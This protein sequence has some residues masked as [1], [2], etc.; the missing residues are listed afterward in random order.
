MTS[1]VLGLVLMLGITGQERS[2][3]AEIEALDQ[4]L[5]RAEA[6]VSQDKTRRDAANLQL[7]QIE[8]AAVRS[9]QLQSSAWTQLQRRV[10]ALARLPATT[11][12]AL[13]QSDTTFDE[14]LAD[15]RLLGHIA[16]HDRVLHDSLV[17]KGD[18][19]QAL[20]IERQNQQARFDAQAQ[21]SQARRDALVAQRQ[22]RRTLLARIRS[23]AQATHAL[24]SETT[25][26]RLALGALAQ[27]RPAEAHLARVPSGAV[28]QHVVPYAPVQ[29]P[30]S[31]ARLDTSTTPKKL[32]SHRGQLAWPATGPVRVAFGERI[33]L[34][35][36]TI[37][38]H[39]G[40]DIGA[41][42]GSRVQAIGPGRIVYAD[43]LRG[44][45]QVVIIDHQDALHAV[46]AHLASIDVN[47]GDA[48]VAGQTLG[49]VGDTGS[50][51]G[52]V[53]YFELRHKGTPVDPKVWL[54]H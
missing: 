40:W 26:A 9:R 33:D 14:A 31:V 43:W 28:V 5:A 37:T 1:A 19:L 18:A 17:A 13:W 36:G 54:R 45:G 3:L 32:Q 21:A 8:V 25:A 39:N 10:R 24:R 7:H 12:L 38:A 11:P 35:Y 34:A 2:V 41:P 29:T 42:L 53:L 20:E 44:Y 6:D 46:V 50:L 4:R 27:T 30:K 16:A 49:T 52:P 51:R 22:S 47:V 23:Q 15:M 48:V